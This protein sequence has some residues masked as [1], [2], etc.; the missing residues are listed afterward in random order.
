MTEEEDDDRDQDDAV[1]KE[2]NVSSS[3]RGIETILDEVTLCCWPLLAPFSA[4]EIEAPIGSDVDRLKAGFIFS[5]I[6]GVSGVEDSVDSDVLSGRMTGIGLAG[7]F[8]FRS[9]DG[10]PDGLLLA[11]PPRGDED[12]RTWTESG[13]C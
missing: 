5:V 8:F 1:K 10:L 2:V 9:S 12:E 4:P 6:L 7:V 3:G 11:D 13:R